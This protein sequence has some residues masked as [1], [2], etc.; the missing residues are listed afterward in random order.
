[1]N[2]PSGSEPRHDADDQADNPRLALRAKFRSPEAIVFLYVF[3]LGLYSIYWSYVANRDLRDLGRR[4]DTMGLGESPLLSTLAFVLGKCVLVPYFW[5]AVMT[6]R[7]IFRAGE[8]V[9]ATGR[10]RAEIAAGLLVAGCAAAVAASL[11]TSWIW[12][13]ALALSAALEID[14]MAYMQLGLNRVWSQCGIGPRPP[15]PAHRRAA[16][17]LIVHQPPLPPVSPRG[18]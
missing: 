14:A 15:S 11:V 6:S 1:M 5:T 16:G 17:N 4:H 18:L 8:V 9:G 12:M 2:Q 3:T 7:R 13:L 10:F